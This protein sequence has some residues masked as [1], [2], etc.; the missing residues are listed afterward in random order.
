MTLKSLR[1]AINKNNYYFDEIQYSNAFSDILL[2]IFTKEGIKILESV[3]DFLQQCCMENSTTTVTEVQAIRAELYMFYSFYEEFKTRKFEYIPLV[4]RDFLMVLFKNDVE[5]LLYKIMNPY[6][7]VNDF[8]T[9]LCENIVHFK[10]Y[11]NLIAIH[12]E[13]PDKHY[14]NEYYLTDPILNIHKILVNLN[15]MFFEYV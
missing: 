2:L 6:E 1:F 8:K 12:G 7:N 13:N 3:K 14:F 15:Q 11:T 10:L 9:K 4:N 5:S